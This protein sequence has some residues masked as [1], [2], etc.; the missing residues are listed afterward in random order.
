MEEFF[1]LHFLEL[2]LQLHVHKWYVCVFHTHAHARTLSFLCIYCSYFSDS[3]I[4]RLSVECCT[5][6]VL[7]LPL[8]LSWMRIPVFCI[9][10]PALLGLFRYFY[11]MHPVLVLSG[12]R[13]SVIALPKPGVGPSPLVQTSCTSVCSCHPRDCLCFIPSPHHLTTGYWTSPLLAWWVHI[14]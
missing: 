12:W 5:A 7:A 3:L 10:H 1:S 6:G 11:V 14:V 4:A 9:L 8:P 13:D 2:F